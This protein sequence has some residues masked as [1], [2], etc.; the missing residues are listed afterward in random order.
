V[1]DTVR[2]EA[3]PATCGVGRL[4]NDFGPGNIVVNRE[5]IT[6]LDV[7]C[8]RTGVQFSDVAYFSTC[9][10]LMG[11]LHLRAEQSCRNLVKDFVAAYFD[12]RAVPRDIEMLLVL[13]RLNAVV[14]ELQ[15]H[16]RR[17]A[18]LPSPLRT[19]AQ[20]FCSRVYGRLIS[21]VAEDAG[22]A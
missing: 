9:I 16:V 11:A 18:E 15:R 13:L 1:R 3:Y 5:R 21:S 22:I 6:V 10:A 4:H 14:R 2:R 17:V 19:A 20:I 7:A 12:N 8:C